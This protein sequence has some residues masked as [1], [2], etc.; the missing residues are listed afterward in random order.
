VEWNEHSHAMTLLRKHADTR[1]IQRAERLLDRPSDFRNQIGRKIYPALLLR[2]AMCS[3]HGH[4]ALDVYSGA[5]MAIRCADGNPRMLIRIFN[6]FILALRTREVTPDDRI[7]H[8]YISPAEQTRLLRSFSYSLLERVQSEPACGPE[9]YRFVSAIGYYMHRCL[10]EGR[11]STDQVAAV[12]VDETV[13]DDTWNLIE[14][15]VAIGLI[16]PIIDSTAPDEMP[17]RGGSFRLS[18]VLAPYFGVLPRR[19]KAR[20]LSAVLAAERSSL[21]LDTTSLQTR[22]QFEG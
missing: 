8:E 2:E 12:T 4:T 7:K 3:A 14:I 18:Y 6:R 10:H 1:T 20:P 16:Y 19:G 11:V 17:I 22:L 13:T 15:A 9:L 21:D 5:L